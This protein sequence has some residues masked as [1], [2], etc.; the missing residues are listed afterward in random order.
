MF[1]DLFLLP[2]VLGIFVLLSICSK[3]PKIL[4]FLPLNFFIILFLVLQFSIFNVIIYA[5]VIYF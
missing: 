2:G 5:V 3:L 1:S 4:I